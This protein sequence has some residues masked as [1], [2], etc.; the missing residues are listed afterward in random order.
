[1]KLLIYHFSIFGYFGCQVNYITPDGK[2][3]Y[4]R[5]CAEN[6]NN[7]PQFE[8]T[9]MPTRMASFFNR[10]ELSNW[11]ESGGGGKN[12]E[13]DI[14]KDIFAFTKGYKV[15]KVPTEVWLESSFLYNNFGSYKKGER[16]IPSSSTLLFDMENDPWQDHPLNDPGV[17]LEML[18][19]LYFMLQI[20]DAPLFQYKRLGLPLPHPR[21]TV[22]GDQIDLSNCTF[23]N[24]E[25]GQRF[26]RQGGRG[27]AYYSKTMTGLWKIKI[28]KYGQKFMK[29]Q[30]AKI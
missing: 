4:M 11:T 24:T 30:L 9:L 3:V 15:M 10:K 25:R 16:E 29:E 17:E 26:I 28:A 21:G 8:Y 6:I 2:Y 18:K 7:G 23:I 1:M 19:K 27:N 22:N 20:H 13:T 5:G 12:T 14:Y